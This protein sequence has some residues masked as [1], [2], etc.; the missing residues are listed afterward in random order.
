MN[1]GRF[2]FELSRS[3]T[4]TEAGTFEPR[5][6]DCLGRSPTPGSSGWQGGLAVS[7]ALAQI[8]TA[9]MAS[10]TDAVLA[11]PKANTFPLRPEQFSIAKAGAG[12]TIEGRFPHPPGPDSMSATVGRVIDVHGTK[13]IAS[14]LELGRRARSPRSVGYPGRWSSSLPPLLPPA[15]M[16]MSVELGRLDGIGHC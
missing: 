7:P 11:E 14:K 9:S 5:P 12:F 16:G 6:L 15:R 10:S 1:W 3:R 13:S 4:A 2:R 8:A